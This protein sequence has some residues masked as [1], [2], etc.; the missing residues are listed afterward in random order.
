MKFPLLPAAFLLLLMA[1]IL[2]GCNSTSSPQASPT[3]VAYTNLSQLA[4]TN[5]EIP[6]TIHGMKTMEPNLNDPTIARYGGIR[7]YTRFVINEK[8]ESETS[9]QIGQMIVEYPPGNAPLAFAG[10]VNQTRASDQSVYKITWLPDPGIGDKSCAFIVADKYG[11]G[12]AIVMVVFVKSNIMES[13]TRIAPAP[14]IDT[15]TRLARIAAA[16]IPA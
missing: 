11:K 13:I 2:A 9:T 12:N 10:F 8:T 7:G 15:Q 3:P 5:E 1:V 14:D 4:F 16:K 6:F